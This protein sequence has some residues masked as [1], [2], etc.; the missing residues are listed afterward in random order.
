M[1]FIDALISAKCIT[2]FSFLF[3]LGFAVQMSRAEERGRL[4]SFYPRRPVGHR[5]IM[6]LIWVGTFWFYALTGFMLLL[7]KRAQ[8]TIAIWAIALTVLPLVIVAR[9]RLLR[10]PV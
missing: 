7:R 4:V 10:R 2:L 6:L 5:A 9:R 3:G 8:K 1:A